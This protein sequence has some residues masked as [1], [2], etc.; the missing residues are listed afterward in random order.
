[1]R[2]ALSKTARALRLAVVLGVFTAAGCGY[3][4]EGVRRP[5]S[6]GEARTISVAGFVNQTNEPG[7][8]GVVTRA[9]RGAFVRDGRL[10]VLDSSDADL[11]LEGVI[12]GYHL[13]PIGFT[14][15]DQ[16][17]RYRVVVRARVRLRDN[18]RNRLV[19][20]RN[21][22]S[23]SEFRINASIAR[24]AVR[25]ESASHKAAESLSGDL[26]ALVLEGF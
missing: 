3:E 4:L 14:G 13:S 2:D 8:G 23:W 19:L 10:R 26:V 21:L 24:S 20:E 1:M 25:R 5:P 17:Q 18:V 6:L 16:A 22:E 12:R 9:V 7:L 11:A 15:A